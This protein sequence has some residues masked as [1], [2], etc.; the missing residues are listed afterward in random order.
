MSAQFQFSSFEGFVAKQDL[1]PHLS[2]LFR[3]KRPIEPLRALH[4]PVYKNRPLLPLIDH[5]HANGNQKELMGSVTREEGEK[6][7]NAVFEDRR[8]EELQTVQASES[9]QD[10]KKRVQ[11][12]KIKK[13]LLEVAQLKK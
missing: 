6:W 4:T 1:L 10:A 7:I 12:Q 5:L 8:P 2:Y 13:N 11:K 9:K 3:A